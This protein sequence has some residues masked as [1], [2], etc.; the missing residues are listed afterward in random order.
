[1][2]V[3]PMVATVLVLAVPATAFEVNRSFIGTLTG[4][5]QQALPIGRPQKAKIERPL[6]T[7]NLFADPLAWRF[8]AEGYTLRSP[9]LAP[10]A[11]GVSKVT[12]PEGADLATMKTVLADAVLADLSRFVSVETVKVTGKHK[13]SRDGSNVSSK[14]TISFVSTTQGP[15]PLPVG[16]GKLKLK[17]KGVPVGKR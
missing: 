9:R 15:N 16:K 1:M 8:F 13:V 14:V 3:L 4:S 2:R 11:K 12:S 6:T 17:F 5:F 7:L 10:T